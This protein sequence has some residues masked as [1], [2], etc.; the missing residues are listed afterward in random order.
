[1]KNICF[2]LLALIAS[3]C[4]VSCTNK[5]NPTPPSTPLDTLRISSVLPNENPAGWAVLINGVN[6]GDVKEIRFGNVS[7]PID[8]NFTGVVTTRVP[9]SMT[10][11]TTT[12]TVVSTNGTSAS[13]SFAVL[14][15]APN[16]PP[17]PQKIVF[18]KKATYLPRLPDGQDNNIGWTNEYGS[19]HS[20]KFSN[21]FG[22]SFEFWNGQAYPLEITKFPSST[23]KTIEVTIDRGNGVSEKYKGE[24]FDSDEVNPAPDTKKQRIIFT[25][26]KGRQI[27]VHT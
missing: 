22:N 4:F 1:M 21:Q 12:L 26:P 6:I 7:A 3:K 18:K 9:T 5:E 11:G 19:N 16:E 24:Y 2:Y 14:K 15:T 8:T 23:D 20:I 10:E 17:H 13:I 25:N 27:V